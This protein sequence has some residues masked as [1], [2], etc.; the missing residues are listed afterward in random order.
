M[1]TANTANAANASIGAALARHY[2]G[3]SLRG[4]QAEVIAGLLAGRDALVVWPTG[5]GK[6]L[7]FQLPALV[8]EDAA[9]T[10]VLSPL[11]ALMQDQVDALLARGI[12][13]TFINSSLSRSERESRQRRL[14][15]GAYRLVYV[16][17]ERFKKPEF[18]A[19]IGQRKIVLFA[20]DEAHC[21]SE[22]GHDFRPEYGKVGRIRA[23]L[24]SPPTI[25]LT[26]TATAQ[27]AADIVAKLGLKEPE[28]FRR[29]VTR[30]NLTL[31]TTI[32]AD[33]DE[34]LDVLS[35]IVA[36]EPGPGIVYCALIRE[37]ER[38]RVHLSKSGREILVYHGE[39]PAAV[40]RREQQTFLTSTSAVVVATNAFGMG[41]D[42][43][44]IRFIVHAQVPGSL[45]SL[46]QEIGRAGRDGAPSRCELLYLE[47]DLLIQKQFHEW[48]NPN[49]RF[50]RELFHVLLRFGDRLHSIDRDD[51]VA[52]L[53]VKNRGDGR[54]D[55]ALA[56]FEAEGIVEGG[57]QRKDLRVVR[58]PTDDEFEELAPSDKR[59]RDLKKLL[60]VVNYVRDSRC[61]RASL[62]R[63]FDPSTDLPDCGTC[64]ACRPTDGAQETV[65]SAAAPP[66]PVATPAHS[67]VSV[68]EWIVVGSNAR[69]RTVRVDSVTV[70]NGAVWIRA[71]SEFDFKA[72]DYDLSRT[73]WEPLR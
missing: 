18:V 47:T 51:L 22:W 31:R 67:P 57:F 14:R 35:R 38:V 4:E 5:S 70:R 1:K 73:E 58:T 13:A 34:K 23:L 46:A 16:T 17:P 29:P 53:L 10:I 71:T 26:A 49:A 48:A 66:R 9:L 33:D 56:L 64:D 6:S 39:L 15:E 12:D 21:I 44:D 25:A 8:G 52:E 19:A 59:E 28:I 61:R 27:T 20:V 41:I 54:V 40:R 30:E 3:F 50:L 7:C 11:I 43:Q 32:V 55:T 65:A 63:Y 2:P 37:V 69:R 68:G 62:E 45:E 24:G 60:D 36:S 42:K 72:R